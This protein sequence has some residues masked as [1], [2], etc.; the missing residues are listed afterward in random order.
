MNLSTSA[1][2]SDVITS[3]RRFKNGHDVRAADGGVY[4]H[5]VQ[6]STE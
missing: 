6:K 2:A 3:T 4:Q 1:A 5:S